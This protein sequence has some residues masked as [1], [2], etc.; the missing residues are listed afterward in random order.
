MWPPGSFCGLSCKFKLG[1]LALN[2]EFSHS[3]LPGGEWMKLQSLV[4][5]QH[6]AQRE[7]GTS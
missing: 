6:L 1:A 3:D 4:H 5:Q 2:F 7:M